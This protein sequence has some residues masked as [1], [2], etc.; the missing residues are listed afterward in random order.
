M[1]D[2][3]ISYDDYVSDPILCRLIK[4][5]FTLDQNNLDGN[6]DYSTEVHDYGLWCFRCLRA[7][8]VKYNPLL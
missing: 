1:T 5:S 7:A 6:D 2:Y 3:F 4:W 8:S